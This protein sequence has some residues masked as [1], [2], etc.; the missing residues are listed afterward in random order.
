MPNSTLQRLIGHG[1]VVALF[2][3]VAHLAWEHTHGGVQS[4]HF[5]ARP[6]LPAI[7]NWWGLIILPSLGWLASRSATRDAASDDGIRGEVNFTFFR[8]SIR[9]FS[10]L[11]FICGGL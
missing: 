10:S 7:S 6:D 3:S 5:L 4:H 2:A 1:F 9:G 8:R 11:V